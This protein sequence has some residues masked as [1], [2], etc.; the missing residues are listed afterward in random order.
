MYIRLL[1]LLMACTPDC[2]SKCLKGID[3]KTSCIWTKARWKSPAKWGAYRM[4]GHSPAEGWHILRLKSYASMK[5]TSLA[6]FHAEDSCAA[7]F[8]SGHNAERTSQSDRASSHMSTSRK[9][10]FCNIVL[11]VR[12]KSSD[13]NNCILSWLRIEDS[14]MQRRCQCRCL[15]AGWGRLFR[16][17]L[18]C[19]SDTY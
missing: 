7:H 16:D 15:V 19:Q 14:P 12:Q 4:R 2:P 10:C 6:V 8:T 17:R 1:N 3:G 13:R 11:R 9:E 5:R 18:L